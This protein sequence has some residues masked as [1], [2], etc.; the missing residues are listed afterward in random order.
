MGFP[1][2]D[3]VRRR[4]SQQG[5]LRV[6]VTGGAGYIGAFVTRALQ[7]AG[8][9]VI[10]FDNL[11]QG[12]RAAVCAPLVV[13]DLTN[14]ADVAALFARHQFDAVVHLAACISVGESVRDPAKY[15]RVNLSGSIQLLDACIQHGVR[16]IVFSSTSEVYGEAQY[17]PL[18]EA[19]PTNP[20]NPYGATKLAVE[21]MLHWY[22][23]AYGIRSISLRYFNAAGA[24]LDG[25]LGEDHH[26]EEHLIPN[27][28]RGA[29]GLQPF[30]L[31]SAPVET[32]DGTTIRDYVH[33]L[34]LADAHVRAIEVLREGHPTDTI[35]LGSG[36]GYSTKE[37][38]TT[39]QRLTGVHFP[40]ERG[41]PRP[42]EPPIK[43]ASYA[44]AEWVLGW[45]PRY[46]LKTMIESALR[47]HQRFPNGYP[48]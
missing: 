37:V 2:T 25:S 46:D 47:W 12:H 35:N 45:R 8:H 42:G 28:I 34:D 24:A 15:V 27:A 17:L 33:V 7:E 13:G 48:E 41:E 3:A 4:P 38:I 32:P 18:D 36:I 14:P 26:P 23:Q 1:Q 10:V 21:Q 31:T 20:S 29:L 30:Q 44:K 9:D 19:H 40:V 6:L 43:Y 5:G 11:S 16:W 39:I 22:D